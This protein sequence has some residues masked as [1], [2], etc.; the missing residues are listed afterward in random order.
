MTVAAI[1]WGTI[2]SF[3]WIFYTQA[4]WHPCAHYNYHILFIYKF[5]FDMFVISCLLW[6]E[7]GTNFMQILKSVWSLPS[8]IYTKSSY[9]L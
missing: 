4:T 7:N 3:N 5:L 1:L 6:A 2:S 8:N 9:K